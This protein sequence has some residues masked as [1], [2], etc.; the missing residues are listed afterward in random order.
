MINYYLSVNDLAGKAKKESYLTSRTHALKI[1]ECI[2][3]VSL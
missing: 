2:L 1:N 3:T